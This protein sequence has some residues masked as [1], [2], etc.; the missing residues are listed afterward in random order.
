MN[1]FIK[2][3]NLISDGQTKGIEVIF[4]DLSLFLSEMLEM[5][6]IIEHFLINNLFKDI[7]SH[8]MIKVILCLKKIDPI[9]FEKIRPTFIFKHTV[10]PWVQT[11]TLIYGEGTLFQRRP[12]LSQTFVINRC[13]T[14]WGL[15]LNFAGCWEVNQM[16]HED[17]LLCHLLL[18]NAT[19]KGA[20]MA[21]WR[22]TTLPNLQAENWRIKPLC[23]FFRVLMMV[24]TKDSKFHFLFSSFHH[25]IFPSF[26]S[27]SFA[28]CTFAN[29]F[30]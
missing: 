23:I 28:L 26:S 4:N 13:S 12:C 16:S 7:S 10:T 29:N 8:C 6:C 22:V 21:F 17:R 18:Q 25:H 11:C 14:L 1:V 9:F 27:P 20:K 30:A 15:Q 3:F 24:I 19:K 2:S 5:D